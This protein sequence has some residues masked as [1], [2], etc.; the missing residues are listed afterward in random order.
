[1]TQWFK[2]INT[3]ISAVLVKK[4]HYFWSYNNFI[5]IIIWMNNNKKNLLINQC[6]S[7]ILKMKVLTIQLKNLLLLNQSVIHML[8]MKK[9][10]I[11]KFWLKMLR[12]IKE[13]KNLLSIKKFH[14]MIMLNV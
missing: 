7:V 5:L 9:Y 3:M 13:L 11:I 10:I 8:Q 2:I 12:K 6:K 4:V 1:M 14:I